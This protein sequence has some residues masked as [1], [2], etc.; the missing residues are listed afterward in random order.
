MEQEKREEFRRASIVV[1]SGA[2]L[3]FVL[4]IVSPWFQPTGEP[5]GFVDKVIWTIG[6]V[7]VLVMGLISALSALNWVTPHDWWGLLKE[8]NIAVGIAT[9]GAAIAVGLALGRIL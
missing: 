2:M 4:C 7:I 8:G 1:S 5:M 9:A 6:M 3:L